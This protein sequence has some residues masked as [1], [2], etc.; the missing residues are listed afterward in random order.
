MKAWTLHPIKSRRHRG[1]LQA[2]PPF[3]GPPLPPRHCPEAQRLV[4]RQGACRVSP[5]CTAGGPPPPRHRPEAQGLVPRQGAR[6]PCVPVPLAA[7]HT[8]CVSPRCTGRR[9]CTPVPLATDRPPPIVE[10]WYT[11][12]GPPQP[13]PRCRTGPALLGCRW[14][15]GAS[16]GHTGGSLRRGERRTPAG[17]PG[18]TVVRHKGRQ[19]APEEL[20]HTRGSLRLGR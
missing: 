5:R 12:E 17:C 14:L 6:G 10:L 15:T 7:G 19:A 18:H 1:R 2:P 13:N 8:Y 9:H 11:G 4:P 3:R 20:R 16:P